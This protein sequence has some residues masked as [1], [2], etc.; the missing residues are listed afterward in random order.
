[1]P[2]LAAE[3]VARGV[4]V[5]AAT[6]DVAS[7]RAAQAATS[8]IPIVFTIGGD[9]VRFGLVQSYSRPGGNMTGISLISSAMGA[10]RI[11]LL[12]EMAPGAK[13]ALFMNPDNPNAAAEQRD[14]ENAARALGHDVLVLPVRNHGDFDAAF[15]RFLREGAGALFVATDP[16][17]LSQ[18]EPLTAFAARQ[19]VPGIY[20]VRE[21]AV[22]G[23]LVSYGPS[24]R[25]MYRQ[26]GVY[27]GRIVGGANPAEM[28]V[29]QP[30]LVEL[31][32]NTKTARALGITL[33]H[34]LLLRASELV[35]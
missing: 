2:A 23:G 5:I 30:T 8:R 16:M 7:A 26:A 19:R 3:L 25:E 29:L 21:F 20:F 33:P 32:I 1:M 18:R 4:A 6:G 10:K 17:L 35:E 12:H 15:E 11:E 34:T 14:A 22:A 27:V 24:I 28:P 13:L 31:V 9:A